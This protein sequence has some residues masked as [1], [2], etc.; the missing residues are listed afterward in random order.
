MHRVL[1]KTP[2]RVF[3]R[4]LHVHSNIVESFNLNS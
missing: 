4:V 2:R 1:V 3:P